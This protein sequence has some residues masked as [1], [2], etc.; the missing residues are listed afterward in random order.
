[1]DQIFANAL[2][3]INIQNSLAAKV[4]YYNNSLREILDE[5]ALELTKTQQKLHRQPW[6]DDMIKPEIAL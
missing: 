6:Y 1:M 5:I 2:S 3:D 4:T